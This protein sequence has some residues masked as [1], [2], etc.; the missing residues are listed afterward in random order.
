MP[1]MPGPGLV[2]VETELIFGGLEAVL[3]RPAAALNADERADRSSCRAPRGEVSQ[4]SISDIAPDQQ[5]ACPQTLDSLHRTRLLRD[6]PTPDSTSHERSPSFPAQLTGVAIQMLPAFWQSLRRLP[7]WLET[8]PR[9]ER[10]GRHRRQARIPCRPGVVP[11]D[12]ADTINR[13]ARYPSEWH[14]VAIALFDHPDCQLRLGGK[15]HVTGTYVA[16]RR[17]GSSV[18]LFGRRARSIKAW[19]WHDT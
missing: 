8:C 9:T 3:D 4:I 19:P 11:F 15:H 1:A 10:H 2:V 18:Q 5:A 14:R 7:Q 12:I 16:F 17:A 13:V 6:R